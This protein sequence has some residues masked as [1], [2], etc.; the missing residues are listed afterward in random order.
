MGRKRQIGTPEG[1][2]KQL[3]ILD[4]A[5]SI[6]MKLGFAATSLDDISDSY[7]ATKGIIYYHFRSKTI[8]FFAVQR[9]AMELTRAAIEPAAASAGPA[10]QR[11]EAMAFAH[12]MLMMEHLD[13]L[14]VAAQG[15]ELQLGGRTTEEERAEIKRITALRDGNERL[16]LQVLEEG[17]ASGEFRE[18]D[19]RIVVKA[20]LGALNWTS[21]WYQPRKTETKK[22]REAIAAEIARYA[23]NGLNR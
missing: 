3:A 16:Y 21:R 13:Y 1:D 18:M 8:L 10:R 19:V 6:F 12:A 17:V 20:L 4:A 22:D 15:L 11:L 7:G 23:V 2:E 9:R 5:A 14:R